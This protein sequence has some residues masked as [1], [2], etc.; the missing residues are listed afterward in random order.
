MRMGGVSC[1]RRRNAD[2]DR[3]DALVVEE[4]HSFPDNLVALFGHS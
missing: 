4:S 1:S 3:T 2:G